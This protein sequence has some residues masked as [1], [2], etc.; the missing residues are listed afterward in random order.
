MASNDSDKFKVAMDE[1]GQNS[2]E[3]AKTEEK[4]SENSIHDYSV[5]KNNDALDDNSVSVYGVSKEYSHESLGSNFEQFGVVKDIV[6]VDVFNSG[7]GL[8]INIFLPL[9][10]LSKYFNPFLHFVA[11]YE[12]FNE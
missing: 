1:K 2:S 9:Y 10:K 12:I 3:K 8:S 7:L 11:Q 4:N 5:D 6:Y